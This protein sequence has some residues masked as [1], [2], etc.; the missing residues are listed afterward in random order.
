MKRLLTLISIIIIAIG[1]SDTN[2]SDQIRAVDASVFAPAIKTTFAGNDTLNYQLVVDTVLY[3]EYE[4][5]VPGDPATTIVSVKQYSIQ[6]RIDTLAMAADST[7][8]D[9]LAYA[10][11]CTIVINYFDLDDDAQLE[12]FSKLD[13]PITLSNYNF[14]PSDEFRPVIGNGTMHV[15]TRPY[16]IFGYRPGNRLQDMVYERILEVIK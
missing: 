11:T 4:G 10:D 6:A 12:S 16:A 3:H 14:L 7:Y 2:T 9:V 5:S 8:G 13:G 15:T 1:C